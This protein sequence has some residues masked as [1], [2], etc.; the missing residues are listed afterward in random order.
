V[1]SLFAGLL[2]LVLFG[3]LLWAQ[4]PT[5]NSTVMTDSTVIKMTKA[6]L[7]QEI[8]ISSINSHP[9]VYKTDPEDLIALRAAGVSNDVIAAILA[10]SNRGQTDTSQ[11]AKDVSPAPTDVPA[12]HPSASIVLRAIVEAEIGSGDLKPAR[13]AKMLVVPADKA[14]P[15]ISSINNLSAAVEAARRNAHND[16][17]RS[18]VDIECL[19]GLVQI[20]LALVTAGINASSDSSQNIQFFDADDSGQFSLTGIKFEGFVIVAIGKVGM[21]GAIWVS[22]PIDSNHQGD[23][24]LDQPTVACYDAQAVF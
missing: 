16:S 18:L 7:S 13:F 6:G 21:N 2:C 11:P 4:T 12:A 17:E 22:E 20:K 8:I 19:K 1:R 10:K 9:G 5:T 14:A 15:A 24:K 23:I 3:G